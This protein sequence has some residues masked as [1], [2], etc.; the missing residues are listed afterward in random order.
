MIAA[1]GSFSVQFQSDLDRMKKQVREQRRRQRAASGQ[2]RQLNEER[3]LLEAELTDVRRQMVALR[4]QLGTA[5]KE[6]LDLSQSAVSGGCFMRLVDSFG[7]HESNAQSFTSLIASIKADGHLD[8]TGCPVLVPVP[9]GQQHAE[10]GGDTP[11]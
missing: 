11:T 5:Q 9:A 8:L 3:T 6:N 1:N 10:Q 7:Q 4:Q 2:Q